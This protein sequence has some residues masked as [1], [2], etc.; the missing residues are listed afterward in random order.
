MSEERGGNQAQHTAVGLLRLGFHGRGHDGLTTSM[1]R[2]GS[3]GLRDAAWELNDRVW[4]RK[5]HSGDAHVIGVPRQTQSL[6]NNP[7]IP[8]VFSRA[9]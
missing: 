8:L 1:V 2:W 5:A 4:R 9:I 7:L 3:P 6:K